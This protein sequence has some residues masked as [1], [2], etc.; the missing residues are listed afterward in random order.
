MSNPE[1]DE[2]I[3]LIKIKFCIING[4]FSKI[5]PKK[6]CNYSV[7]M[8]LSQTSIIKTNVE[9]KKVPRP[10]SCV[11]GEWRLD[12]HA[13][14]TMELWRKESNKATE[15]TTER[16]GEKSSK[17]VSS[18]CTNKSEPKNNLCIY[19]ACTKYQFKGANVP[20][21]ARRSYHT[22]G[23]RKIAFSK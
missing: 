17:L 15:S 2:T 7:Q 12:F 22:H 16:P 13:R 20:W 18:Y 6:V 11:R 4:A 10:S 19:V 8:R 23:I 3:L 1:A 5:F 9:A 14:L 21:S